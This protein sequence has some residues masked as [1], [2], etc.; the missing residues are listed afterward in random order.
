MAAPGQFR[1]GINEL[2]KQAAWLQRKVEEAQKT[3]KERT[4]T[5][6]GANDKV[7]VTA[8]LGREVTRIE[9]DPAFLAADAEFALD[10]VSGVVNAA[11]KSAAE[12]MDKEIQ[13]ATGGLKIPGIT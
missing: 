2:M 13:K 5:V 1:G 8:T 7:K 12:E 10:A 9:V 3:N 6:S 11:L 4:V